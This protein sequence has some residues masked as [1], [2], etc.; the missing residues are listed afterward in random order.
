MKRIAGALDITTSAL[1]GDI[2]GG[3]DELLEG[4]DDVKILKLIRSYCKLHQHQ[5][6]NIREIIKVIEQ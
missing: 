1:Y 5:Q 2:K 6:D 3:V 4:A